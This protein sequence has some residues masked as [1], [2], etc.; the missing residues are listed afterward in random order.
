MTD[1]HC[2]RVGGV[3]EHFNL[4]W[5]LA[6]ASPEAS[7]RQAAEWIDYSTGTGAMLAD[8]VDRQ[9]DLAVLLTEGAALGVARQLPIEAVSLYTTSPLIWGVHVPAGARYRATDELEG[10]RFAI[11]RYGSGSHLMSL[12][13]AIERGWPAGGLQFEVVNDLPGAID[14]FREGRADAFL[15][16]HFT[17]QPVVDAGD[18]RRVGDFVAPWPAWVLCAHATVWRERQTEIEHLFVRVCR[19]AGR[20]AA[21]SDSAAV[22]AARYGL[23]PAA[24]EQWLAKT[25]W[26]DGLVSPA[27]GLTAARAMLERAAVV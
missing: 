17:T 4:P 25:E 8:L 2:L 10:A 24:V 11:S 26:V 9:L 7:D 20:L 15:W 23:A 27:A 14:A 3:P 18:F 22:I 6:L 21:D 19:H 5:H 12:A 16:E 13:M 1:Q